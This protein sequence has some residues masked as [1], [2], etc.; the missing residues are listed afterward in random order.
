MIEP[1]NFSVLMTV[2]DRDNDEY[3]QLAF[4][5]IFEDQSLKPTE[6]ILV[7][8]GPISKSKAKIIQKYKKTL[9]KILKLVFI[10]NNVGLAAALNKGLDFCSNQLIARMDSDDISLSSRFHSQ[11]NFMCNNLS[12]DVCGTYISE[13]DENGKIIRKMVKYPLTHYSLY[14]FF[15]KRDPFAHSSVMFRKSFFEKSGGYQE[16]FRRNQDSVL[17]FNGF[18]N[19]AVFA[20]LSEIGLLFRRSNSFYTKKTDYASAFQYL[21]Y[22]IQIINKK[23]DYGWDADIFAFLYFLMHRLP[24]ELVRVFYKFF[25]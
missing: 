21:K 6:I 23:L 15:K 17:W 7:V 10:S 9:P 24:R 13:I 1:V 16:N 11:V 19:G 3:F 8:D 25:R 18:L 2:C 20:N 22:R 12:V 5:S 14:K 4:K